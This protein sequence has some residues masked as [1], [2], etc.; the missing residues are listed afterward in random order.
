MS[1]GARLALAAILPLLLLA[2]CAARQEGPPTVR[3]G[4]DEC[5][6]CHMILG[7]ERFAAVAR[8]EAGEEARFD[9]LG[10]LLR[11]SESHTGAWK[12]WAHDAAGTDWLDAE[13]AFY[14]RNAT[15]ATPMGSGLR[16]W[17][18][19]EA[20]IGSGDLIGS[21]RDLRAAGSASQP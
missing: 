6:Q 20:A 14:T 13:A 3:W 11:W 21:W 12:T 2:S 7:D 19:R 4:V 17:S 15:L 16:A 5:S 18:S 8:D 10:C 1:R 9:D